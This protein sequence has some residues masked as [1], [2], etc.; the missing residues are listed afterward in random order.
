MERRLGDLAQRADLP[1]RLHQQEP[2]GHR[3]GQRLRLQRREHLGQQGLGEPG[4]QHRPHR[5]QRPGERGLLLLGRAAR[6][7]R[8][9][10]PGPHPGAGLRRRR[11]LLSAL[12]H[13]VLGDLGVSGRVG[14]GQHRPVRHLARPGHHALAGVRLQ[15]HRQAGDHRRRGVRRRP[16]PAPDAQRRGVRLPAG[17]GRHVGHLLPPQRHRRPRRGHVHGGRHQGDRHHAG[18]RLLRRRAGPD[19]GHRLR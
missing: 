6:P 8:Q 1:E 9:H 7:R 15:D 12:R 4:V 10:H 5:L 16:D 2:D 18:R 17:G 11:G 3:P 14:P 13:Q 19:R